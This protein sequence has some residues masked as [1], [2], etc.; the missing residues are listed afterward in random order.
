ME[1]SKDKGKSERLVGNLR[2]KVGI[3][4]HPLQCEED[5]SSLI[6]HTGQLPLSPKINNNNKQLK[7][8]DKKS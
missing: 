8:T 7:L 5:W 2:P 4:N 1:T 3:E 6:G